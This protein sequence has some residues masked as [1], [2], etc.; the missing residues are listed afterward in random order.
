MVDEVVALVRVGVRVVYDIV[1]SR[2]YLPTT[3]N[4]EGGC[5]TESHDTT[6]SVLR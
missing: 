1:D 3:L 2:F 4:I 6:D 5:D